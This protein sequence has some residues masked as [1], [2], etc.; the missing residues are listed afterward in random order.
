MLC[1]AVGGADLVLSPGVDGIVVPDL[2]PTSL[3]EGIRG[4]CY[5]SDSELLGMK[6]AAL[7]KSKE[8]F[9]PENYVAQMIG[10][11][12]ALRGACRE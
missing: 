12:G 6:R 1:N 9:Q 2:E 7:A 8:L 11:L 10:F 5:M 4:A 3:A